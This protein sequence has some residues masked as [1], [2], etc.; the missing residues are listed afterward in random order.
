MCSKRKIDEIT[1]QRNLTDSRT[2]V[3]M[4]GDYTRRSCW[5][6]TMGVYET[7]SLLLFSVVP[8]VA[9]R[10]LCPDGVTTGY[11][12]LNGLSNDI[13]VEAT[14]IAN[15]GTPLMM[16]VFNICPGAMIVIP[17]DESLTPRLSGSVFRCG[18]DG[19]SSGDCRFTGGNVQVNMAQSTIPGYPVSDVVFEGMTFT[20][21][22]TAALSGNADDATT[23]M[24]EDVIFTVCSDDQAVVVWLDMS[25]LASPQDYM[26]SFGV[27]QSN[28]GT[29]FNVQVSDSLVRGASGGTVFSTDGG[30]LVIADTSFIDSNS[31]ALVSSSGGAAVQATDIE[32]TGGSIEV[33]CCHLIATDGGFITDTKLFIGWIHDHGRVQ[34][35]REQ[36]RSLCVD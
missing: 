36:H 9:Q 7:L 23:V 19:L 25:H 26:A 15:G 17:Q 16:Y 5:R 20:N 8:A 29:P 33:R 32:V 1:N 22:N 11:S 3:A 18:N 34:V 30:S 28:G 31:A 6:P 12:T 10:A 35:S 27:Q 2:V 4:R 24:F 13:N 14:R 21:F